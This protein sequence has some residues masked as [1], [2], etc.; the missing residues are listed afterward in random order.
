[1]FQ[2]ILSFKVTLTHHY[3]DF[4]NLIHVETVAVVATVNVFLSNL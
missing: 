4:L 3:F 2:V 1:M